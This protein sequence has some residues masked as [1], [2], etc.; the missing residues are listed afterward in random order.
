MGLC[1]VSFRLLLRCFQVLGLL[2]FNLLSNNSFELIIGG[3]VEV[4]ITFQGE[5]GVSGPHLWL[6]GSVEEGEGV[7][8]EM[9]LSRDIGGLEEIKVRSI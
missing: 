2:L 6:G 1:L 9:S 8:E 3:E 5:R 4:Y 7:R